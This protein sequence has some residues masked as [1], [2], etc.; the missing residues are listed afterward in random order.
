MKIT[1]ARFCLLLLAASASGAG[2]PLTPAPSPPL[3]APTVL[4]D[5][6]LIERDADGREYFLLDH[7]RL[8]LHKGPGGDEYFE[9]GSYRYST[10]PWRN[11]ILLVFRDGLTDEQMEKHLAKYG[12]P[13]WLHD[14]GGTH[15]S[16]RLKGITV[17]A[18]LQVL[19]QD[20]AVLKAEPDALS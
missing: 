18:A 14:R 1:M 6:P 2:V 9:L 15:Y 12:E 13:Q 20:P 4:S 19:K 11:N 16:V 5:N 10:Q 7:Q 3:P 17:R 8:P